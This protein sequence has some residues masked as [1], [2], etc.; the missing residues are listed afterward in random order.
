MFAPIWLCRDGQRR[1][2][3]ELNMGDV[4][5]DAQYRQTDMRYQSDGTRLLLIFHKETEMVPHMKQT[6]FPIAAIIAVCISGQAQAACYAD[7][8]AKRD[9]PLKLHYGVIKIEG[10][11]CVMSDKVQSMVADRLKSEG[12]KL[13]NVQSVFDDGGLADRKKDAGE[14]FLRF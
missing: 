5:F 14:F 12:W 6:L 8:K 10:D 3:D 7:Y 9:N 2:F 1:R 11:P 4:W 13:L